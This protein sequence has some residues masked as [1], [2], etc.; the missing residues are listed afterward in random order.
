MLKA[1]VGQTLWN[2]TIPMMIGIAAIFLF[3]IV[4]TFYIGQLGEIQLAAVSFTFPVVLI[5]M[6]ISMGIG[7]GASATIAKA[8]GGGDQQQVQRLTTDSLMLAI[9]VV[10]AIAS[11]GLVT[12]DPVFRLL[13]ADEMYLPMIHDYMAVWYAGIGFVVIP[14]VGNSAIRATGDAKTPSVIMLV[15]GIVNV[16]LDPF[17]IFGIGPFP[18]MELQGAALA[19]IIAYV[20]AFIAALW[21]LVKREKMICFAIPSP[22]QVLQSWKKIGYIGG[23]AA[24]TNVLNP[25]SAGILTRIIA[26]FGPASVAAYGVGTRIESLAM[27]GVMALSSVLA[28]FVGQNWGA[29]QFQRVQE[30][31]KFSF[32]FSLIWGVGAC[33][34][35]WVTAYPIAW[36]FT[37]EESVNTLI[38]SFFWIVPVSYGFYGLAVL[39]ASIFTALLKPF[40]AA[41]LLITRLFLFIIPLA[42]LGGHW[43]GVIGVFFGIAAGNILIA[44]VSYWMVKKTMG[45]LQKKETA[46]VFS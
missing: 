5:V 17:L 21:I 43:G 42:Y 19:T 32:R 14:M 45:P 29:Q 23:P 30:G 46:P 6:S 31:V 3:N 2:M 4:D 33:L 39:G 13:G 25:L 20:A 10:L 40:H 28:P 36:I 41:F 16:I 37:T 15:A 26:D 35:L 27:I 24:F 12:I 44:P 8:L 18:R 11:L 38:A 34:V 9:I 22:N 7:M 1:P